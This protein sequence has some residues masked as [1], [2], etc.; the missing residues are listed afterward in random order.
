MSDRL[1][2]EGDYP[3]AAIHANR[4]FKL[5]WEFASCEAVVWAI[6]LSDV[7]RRRRLLEL[8][9]RGPISGLDT[10]S[11]ACLAAMVTIAR[12]RRALSLE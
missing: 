9:S 11:F 3:D 6:E 5:V 1:H 12:D 7:E 8:V 4:S 2:N 10:E